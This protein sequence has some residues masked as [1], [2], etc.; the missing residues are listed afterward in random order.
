MPIDDL[1][2]GTLHA[3]KGSIEQK[4]EQAI[5]DQAKKEAVR[6][7]PGFFTWPVKY[8]GITGLLAAGGYLI[9][10]VNAFLTSGAFG[11]GYIVECG[12]N[13][14]KPTVDKFFRN[15]WKGM[16]MGISAYFI[17]AGTEAVAKTYDLGRT[18]LGKV[19]KTA[20]FNPV[21]VGVFNVGF[22]AYTHA[23]ERYGWKEML[24]PWKWPQ[25]MGTLYS[26]EL[27]PRWAK[28]TA[29]TMKIFFPIHFLAQ[30]YISGI[31]AR[32]A[33]GGMNDIIYR[34]VAPA[35]KKKEQEP[36]KSPAYA[37]S[38]APSLSQSY[39]RNPIGM[40]P[41]LGFA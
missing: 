24:K 25:Y 18:F 16:V 19:A 32:M 17:Y 6:K 21:G 36:A 28:L 30:N 7:R 37:P 40:Q 12:K 10:G 20:I 5:D 2:N 22:Q 26:E 23:E 29:K 31:T 14:V 4:V 15:I 8:L 1:V 35:E 3:E 39:S 33:I 13:K 27:K 41:R 38:P 9:T 34:L 11:I